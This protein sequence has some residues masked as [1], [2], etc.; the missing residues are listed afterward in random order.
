MPQPVADEIRR[1]LVAGVEQEDALM[2]ELGLGEPLA[3]LL[4]PDEP[5]QHV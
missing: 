2:I 1:G 4:A 3:I 5:R